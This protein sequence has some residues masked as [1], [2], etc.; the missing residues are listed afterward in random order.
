MLFAHSSF[1]AP[2]GVQ[3]SGSFNK[4]AALRAYQRARGDYAAI[5]GGIEPMIIGGLLRSRGFRP[6]YR[7]RAPA[8]T[9]AEADALCA[10]LL[11]VGG[12]CVVL[13]S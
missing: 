8:A 9:R 7:V 3:I 6:F 12:A 5:L 13:R 2:W 10:K 11:K 4:E 1:S